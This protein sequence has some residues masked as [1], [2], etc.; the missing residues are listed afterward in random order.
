M[1]TVKEFK[2]VTVSK[3]TNSFG[4]YGVI[5]MA[6]DGEAWELGKSYFNLPKKSAT[7]LV[8]VQPFGLDWNVLGFEIPR[9]LMRAPKR[10]AK[11]VWEG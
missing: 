10:V 6:R 7:V 8:P 2:V 11:Q 4:L 3:N 9:K 5:V 1:M